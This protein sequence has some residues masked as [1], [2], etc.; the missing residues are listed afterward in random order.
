MRW[1][2]TAITKS[3][4]VCPSLRFDGKKRSFLAFPPWK[5]VAVSRPVAKDSSGIHA[6]SMRWVLV[7]ANS[8]HPASAPLLLA[9]VAKPQLLCSL[10]NKASTTKEKST[11]ICSRFTIGWLRPS[12]DQAVWLRRPVPAP[13]F[14]CCAIARLTAAPFKCM[15]PVPSLWQKS[16]DMP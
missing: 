15:T 16:P 11:Q 9:Q 7:L 4:R 14:F 6:V 10:S 8:M 3:C 1:Q 12:V 13:F 2:I 5:A